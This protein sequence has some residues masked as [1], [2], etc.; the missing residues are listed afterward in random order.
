MH[1]RD[2]NDPA[3]GIARQS[4]VPEECA[5]GYHAIHTAGNYLRKFG[6][7]NTDAEPAGNTEHNIA[8][9]YWLSHLK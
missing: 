8:V 5:A 7:K 2:C 1:C 4:I 3:R 6:W 9:T